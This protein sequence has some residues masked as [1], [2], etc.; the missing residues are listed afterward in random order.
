MK[1]FPKIFD[2]YKT[3][4]NKISSLKKSLEEIVGFQN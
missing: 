3:S 1:R 2:I 4:P